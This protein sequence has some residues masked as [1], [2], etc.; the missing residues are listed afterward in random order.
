MFNNND[1]VI[2]KIK[3]SFE[4]LKNENRKFQTKIESKEQ[5]HINTTQD[6]R[7]LITDLDR[8]CDHLDQDIRANKL[9]FENYRNYVEKE[10]WE[11]KH[12]KKEDEDEISTAFVNKIDE[13]TKDIAL[14][15]HR[16][17]DDQLLLKEKTEDLETKVIILTQAAKNSIEGK[18][19]TH[20]FDGIGDV[21]AAV[22]HFKQMMKAQYTPINEFKETE[23]VVED[24]NKFYMDTQ[25]T[26][27]KE[28]KEREELI[29]KFEDTK[30]M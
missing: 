4:D 28:K 14:K 16:H 12:N 27:L 9:E 20:I 23:K 13:M 24:L 29:E 10:K 22:D 5:A 26:K 11:E 3:S 15:V 30:Y 8:K 17:S 19:N 1:N 6:I 21:I 18:P 7:N 2:K 25:Q